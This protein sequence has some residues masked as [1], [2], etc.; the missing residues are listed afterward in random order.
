MKSK[1][2]PYKAGWTP[3]RAEHKRR[4]EK[5]ANAEARQ[6]VR[7]QR[8]DQEQLELLEKRGHGYTGHGSCKEA[9][10]LNARILKAHLDSLPDAPIFQDDD[11]PREAP[12]KINA[13]PLRKRRTKPASL[14]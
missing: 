9:I 5:T 11:E 3:R 2:E 6:A 1:G 12:K 13:R 4:A 14:I 10:R 7:S 8:T